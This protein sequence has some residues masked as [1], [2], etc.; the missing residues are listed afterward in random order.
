MSYRQL[1]G[2]LREAGVRVVVARND[3]AGYERF[4]LEAGPGFDVIVVGGVQSGYD[5]SRALGKGA[6]AVQVG[7]ALRDEGPG[8][9]ARLAREM[10]VARGQRE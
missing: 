9:F 4:K 7:T 10:R 8:I 5:V 6:K 3:F 2:V 1:G